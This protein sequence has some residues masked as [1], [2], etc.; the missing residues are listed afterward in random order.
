M[1]LPVYSNTCSCNHKPVSTRWNMLLI[2]WEIHC[3]CWW[4]PRS[5]DHKIKLCLSQ[6]PKTKEYM[7]RSNKL[8]TT[9]SFL[10]KTGIVTMN[11][12]AEELRNEPLMLLEISWTWGVKK[13]LYNA[14]GSL[15]IP[16]GRG[17]CS[18]NDLD[19]ARVELGELEV[20]ES[21]V[22]VCN[23]N[24]LRILR[25]MDEARMWGRFLWMFLRTKLI[26]ICPSGCLYSRR[27]IE[28]ASRVCQPTC[29]AIA[30]W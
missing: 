16:A 24:F 29:S 8:V 17:S 3:S 28:L 23:E 10:K 22:L 21:V 20:L 25:F 19:R 6:I 27:K 2:P 15:E 30:W 26:Q 14:S 4:S 12:H 9:C 18:R 13:F 5:K 11:A 7:N 1:C